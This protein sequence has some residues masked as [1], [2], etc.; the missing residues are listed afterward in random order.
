[1]DIKDLSVVVLWCDDDY[2]YL[3]DMIKS[4]PKCEL[5]LAKTCPVK[6]PHYSLNNQSGFS[7]RKSKENGAIKEIE[8]EYPEGKLHFSKLRNL[9]KSISS[10]EI[11]LSIDP[12]ERLLVHQHEGWAEAVDNL[13][14]NKDYGGVY[15]FNISIL[16]HKKLL[17]D[18]VMIAPQVRLFKREFEWFAPAHETIDYD[19]KKK[20]KKI[21]ASALKIDHVGYEKEPI[22]LKE[23]MRR[24]LNAFWNYIEEI[25]DIQ[26][27]RN[28]FERD[29]KT[30][31]K[32]GDENGN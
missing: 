30:Y 22:L 14:K 12:D 24:N 8:I 17:T 23:K 11:I 2:Q 4:L 20:G 29:L 9:A 15:S 3:K 18:M 19:I 1:M 25:K 21:F 5:I 6:E 27:Y 13:K 16:T 7:I 31:F 26:H 32:L 10:N 28:I